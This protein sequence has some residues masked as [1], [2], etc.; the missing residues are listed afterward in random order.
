MGSLIAPF[1]I[2]LHG[3]PLLSS[4]GK[5]L[6]LDFWG[7]NPAQLFNS[8]P[9]SGK[10]TQ[11]LS[12]R[13]SSSVNK[14]H[15]SIPCKCVAVKK[16]VHGHTTWRMEP[17]ESVDLNVNQ[18]LGRGLVHRPH[19]FFTVTVPEKGGLRCPSKEPAF[20]T[21]QV[22]QPWLASFTPGNS[23]LLVCLTAP[24]WGEGLGRPHLTQ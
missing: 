17:Y 10:I 18:S 19:V 24:A 9:T 21:R 20:G 13:A 12:A 5:P 23:E 16:Q 14:E 22:D 6:W 2:C 7:S 8:Q 4:T 11:P 1:P 15:H 3:H